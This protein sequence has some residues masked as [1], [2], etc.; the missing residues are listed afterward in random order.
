VEDNAY[1]NRG[2]FFDVALHR[3]SDAVI[4]GAY[5]HSEVVVIVPAAFFVVRGAARK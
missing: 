4:A 1:F 3:H 2:T 5:A